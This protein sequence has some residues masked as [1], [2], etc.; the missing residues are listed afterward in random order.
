MTYV[1]LHQHCSGLSPYIKR[2]AIYE[3]VLKI[4]GIRRVAHVIMDL[5]IAS[6]RGLYLSSRN[7]N[8]P[9]V[10]Q[11]GGH[12]IA[13]ARG[14]S[15]VWQRFVFLKE[16]MHVFDDPGEATDSGDVFEHL[17][18]EFTQPTPTTKRSP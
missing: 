5:D 4:K 17:L 7:T 13:T 1:D 6:C 15:P 18:A 16:L 12:V 11:N 14:L 10:R 3:C 8:P 2:K 9:F